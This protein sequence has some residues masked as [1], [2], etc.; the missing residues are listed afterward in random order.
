MNINRQSLSSEELQ[1][2]SVYRHILITMTPRGQ[3]VGMGKLLI[4]VH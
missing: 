1:M 2:L 3:V 4:C